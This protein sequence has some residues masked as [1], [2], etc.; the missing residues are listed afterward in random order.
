MTLDPKGIR[1]CNPGNLRRSKDPWQGLAEQQDDP[2]F[3]EFKAPVWGIRALAVTLITYQ[4]RRLAAD[5]SKIDT[6]SEVIHRW[7]PLTENKTA[8]YV[9]NVCRWTGFKV[10][11]ILD[12]HRYEDVEP[13][14]KAI[15]RMENGKQPYPQEV[16][17]EGLRMAGVL[18]PAQSAIHEPKVVI[19]T[20]VGAMTI[21]QQVV[22]QIEPVWNFLQQ[23]F[24]NAHV[25]TAIFGAVAICTVVWFVLDWWGKRRIG[26]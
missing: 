19:P 23:F 12:L 4:D 22:T 6:V 21:A 3:F 10:Y 14:V 2:A 24:V 26:R 9:Q 20:V 16:T 15:I 25:F 1:L 11:Q 18:R 7:A 17:D 8:T 13:L 5:G